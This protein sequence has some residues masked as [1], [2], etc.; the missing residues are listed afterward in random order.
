MK[1]FTR[2]SGI[3]VVAFLLSGCVVADEARGRFIVYLTP[4][5]ATTLTSDADQVVL[6]KR[7]EQS[8]QG[9]ITLE[10]TLA[11]GGWVVTVT[12][13]GD[14]GHQMTAV[15]HLPG[16]ASAERDAILQHQ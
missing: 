11:T 13:P 4:E 9:T 6:L 15:E 2:W 3:P 8:L 1:M 5:T 7:W 14:A 16:V 12:S 10:R